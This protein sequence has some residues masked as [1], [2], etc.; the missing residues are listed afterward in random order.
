MAFIRR[1][2][3]PDTVCRSPTSAAASLARSRVGSDP[4]PL[5]PP[6]ALSRPPPRDRGRTTAPNPAVRA[7][8]SR[9]PPTSWMSARPPPAPPPA[10]PTTSSAWLRSPTP[11]GGGSGVGSVSDSATVSRPTTPPAASSPP[12]IRPTSGSASSA[13]S[14]PRRTGSRSRRFRSTGRPGGVRTQHPG[15]R[16]DGPIV[17]AWSSENGVARAWVRTDEESREITATPEWR[18]RLDTSEASVGIDAAG[19]PKAVATPV[20]AGGGDD[21]L[22]VQENRPRLFGDIR[23]RVR[24]ALGTDFVGRSR[25]PTDEHSH[26][27]EELRFGVVRTNREAIRDRASWAGSP[28]VAGV[29]SRRKGTGKKASGELRYCIGRRRGS[30]KM[31]RGASRKHWS[32]DT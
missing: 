26:G 20:V 24:G 27:R 9:A 25:R 29:V 4:V 23:G 14:S 7:S 17:G 1:R 10:G 19:R 2:P 31:S 6:G 30:G 28:S 3:D 16:S 12:S 22:A 15:G 32:T 5:H 8:N 13:G 21:R 18:A 11:R